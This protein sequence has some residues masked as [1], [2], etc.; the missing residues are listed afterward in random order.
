MFVTGDGRELSDG[1]LRITDRKKDVI[2]TGGEN[3]SSIQVESV[4]YGH[5]DVVEAAVIGVSHDRWG[6]TVK[7]L[8]LLREGVAL[9]AL[10]LIAP[11]K[12]RMAGGFTCPTSI[13]QRDVLPRTATGKIQK[14]R[15]REPYWA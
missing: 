15:L 10:A 4:L 12:E 3:V 7:A 8:V 5:P 13:E 11:C 6:E 9:D 2:V 1:T 14:F